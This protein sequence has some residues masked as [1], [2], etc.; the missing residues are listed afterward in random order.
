[1]GNIKG[2][3]LNCIMESMR[4]SNGSEQ[5]ILKCFKNCHAQKVRFFGIPVFLLFQEKTG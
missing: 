3:M 5:L 4:K 2:S 1:M